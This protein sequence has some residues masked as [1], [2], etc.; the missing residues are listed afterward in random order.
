MLSEIDGP[1]VERKRKLHKIPYALPDDSYEHISETGL[2]FHTISRLRRQGILNYEE[3]VIRD[4]RNPREVYVK[5]EKIESWIKSPYDRLLYR[6]PKDVRETISDELIPVAWIAKKLGISR[7]SVS[8]AIRK[9]KELSAKR[10]GRNVLI[11]IEDAEGWFSKLPD[12]ASAISVPR[13]AKIVGKPVEYILQL[14]ERGEI[15]YY[16]RDGQIMILRRSFEKL[17]STFNEKV[18]Y[19]SKL[20]ESRTIL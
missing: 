1:P 9:K 13:A 5:R 2:S 3:D 15:E 16:R 19:N 12:K 7:E 18:W 4:E 6:L 17:K 11:S 14:A 20:N 10:V 8:Y